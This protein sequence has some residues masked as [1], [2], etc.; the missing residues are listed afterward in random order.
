MDVSDLL[1]PV[2]MAEL[3]NDLNKSVERVNRHKRF[4]NIKGS[5]M[6][7]LQNMNERKKKRGMERM[8]SDSQ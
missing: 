6:S 7:A 1:D 3:D 5:N 2:K 4:S 8:D